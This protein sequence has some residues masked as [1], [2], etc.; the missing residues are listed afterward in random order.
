[1]KTQLYLQYWSAVSAHFLFT[2]ITRDF[3]RDTFFIRCLNNIFVVNH[4]VL[5]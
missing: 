1:M 5:D 4:L 2:H 3:F